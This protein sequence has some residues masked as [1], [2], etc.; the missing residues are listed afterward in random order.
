MSVRLHGVGG[1]EQLARDVAEAQG[2]LQQ[3]Q[4]VQL[5]VGEWSAWARPSAV[6]ANDTWGMS[7]RPRSTTSSIASSARSRL[8]SGSPCSAST[9]DPAARLCT[10]TKT[11]AA[12][13]EY[14][15][16]STVD[17]SSRLPWT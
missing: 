17:A 14:A 3:A 9:R 1:Q 8:R 4:H 7:P 16:A 6:Y 13:L 2:A 12:T 5:P 11:G 15:F 10:R